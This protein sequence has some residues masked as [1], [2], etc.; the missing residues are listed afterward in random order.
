V[1]DT[2]GYNYRLT[3]VAAALGVAQLEQLPR[4]LAAKRSLAGRYATLLADLP[5]TPA[6]GAGWARASYWL[7]SVLLPGERDRVLTALRGA[8]VGARPLWMATH[9]QVPYAGAERI[10]G[11]VA[12]DLHRRG[13]SLPSSTS[14]STVDQDRTVNA[15]A[16]A[17]PAL[18]SSN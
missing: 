6:P 5:V 12:E 4:F 9:Q 17:V 14:L 3:N 16:A 2:V 13:L 11:I 10:G 7:Y 18:S 15:L 8:G 1:H